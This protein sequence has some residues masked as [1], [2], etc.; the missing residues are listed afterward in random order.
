MRTDVM[1]GLAVRNAEEHD[2]ATIAEIYS[3]AVRTMPATFELEPPREREMLERMRAIRDKRCPYLVAVI[4]CDVVGYAYAGP[5]RPRPAY[6]YTVEDSVYVARA[7][8][9]R[10]IGALLLRSLID[11]CA[12]SGFRQMIAVIGGNAPGSIALHRAAGFEDVGRLRSV[13]RKFDQWLDTTLMQ[14]A[15]GRGDSSPPSE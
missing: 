9:G 5:Y 4:G 13:G 2:T 3:D 1:A 8:H 11:A 10:G 7:M 12:A 15:L 6:R 14:R